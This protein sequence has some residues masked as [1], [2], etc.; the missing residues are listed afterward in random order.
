MEGPTRPP[1]EESHA[2]CVHEPVPPYNGHFRNVRCAYLGNDVACRGVLVFH[3]TRNPSV[4]VLKDPNGAGRGKLDPICSQ[5]R[6]G[7]QPPFKPFCAI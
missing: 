1:F 6:L 7:P 3:D 2:A 5:G 4:A